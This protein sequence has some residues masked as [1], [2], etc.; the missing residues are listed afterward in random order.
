M[1]IAARPA[2]PAPI[3]NTDAGA[4]LPAA[5][6][7][8]ANMPPY[9][10]ADSTTARYPATFDI[11]LSTS[12]DCAREMRGTASSARAVTPRSASCWTSASFEPGASIAIR[13][14]P[15]DSDATCSADGLLT[16]VTTSAPHACV[17]SPRLAPASTYASSG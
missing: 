1:P 6:T 7:W 9:S 2:T 14:A 4:V 17:A 5:V 15:S 12:S 10:S 3:T 16:A 13:V 11:A 8:P